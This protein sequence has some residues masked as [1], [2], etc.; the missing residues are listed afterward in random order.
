VGISE[1]DF[2]LRVIDAVARVEQAYWDLVAARQAVQVAEDGV[3]LGQEQLART[4]RQIAAGTLAPVEISLARSEF[5]RRRD[6]STP[7]RTF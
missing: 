2:E 3:K 5:E 6:S 4:E 1:T 7:R